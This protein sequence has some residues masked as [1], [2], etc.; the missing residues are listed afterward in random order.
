MV[1][2][3]NAYLFAGQSGAGKS[4][5]ALLSYPRQILSDE[6]AIL[7]V[8]AGRVEVFNSPF[9]SYSFWDHAQTADHYELKGCHLLRQSQEIKRTPIA[10]SD[11]LVHL[12]NTVFYWAYRADETAKVFQLGSR[13][14]KA[15]P[16]Y[17]L[18]FQKNALFWDEI[19]E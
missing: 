16:F 5:A 12:M 9:R 18:F 10:P 17:E 19:H 1:D 14:V 4:T 15:V 8:Q 7:K 13:V 2:H 6:A 11:A 3:E